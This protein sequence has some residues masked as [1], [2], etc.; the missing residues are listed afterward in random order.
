MNPYLIIIIAILAARYLTELITDVLNIRNLTETLP[1]EFQGWYDAD[2]YKTSQ[3]YLR[4][5]TRF[6]T[7]G[8]S[9]HALIALVFLLAGGFNVIDQMARSF[10]R[11]PIPT[12]LIFTG[13]LVL[14]LNILN[15]PFSIYHT[16]V[17]EE[18]YG[19]NKT[20]PTTFIMDIVK[21]IMLTILIGG[22]ALAAILWFFEKTGDRAWMF[23]WLAVVLFQ[24]FLL[25][26]APY[27]IMP[28]FNKFVPLDNGDL[29]TAIEGYARSQQFKMKGVF[30]MDGSKRSSKTNAFFTGFGKSRRIVLFDTLIEK[31]TIPELV[32]IVGH[33]MGHYKKQHILQAIMRSIITTGFMFFLLSLFIRNRQLFDAFRMEHL[34]IYA[35]LFFFGFLY[36]PIAMVISIIEN[37]ISR[38]QEYEAD[39]Y[40]VETCHNAESMITGLKKL[41]VVNLSNLTPHPVK[42]FFDYSHPPVLQRIQVMQGMQSYRA[43]A[44]AKAEAP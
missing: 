28:L 5:N 31:H 26:I 40:A 39:A 38:K 3:N 34:S 9:F 7:V 23:C 1:T 15:L 21:S 42:V 18:K 44:S 33:E 14:A 43:E 32:S 20:T 10:E 24:V 4:E 8:D 30:K 22:I 37:V 6:N 19:F 35:S 27:V 17:I 29:R 12:G 13:I 41:S 16:F 11:G 36:T 2:K 25:F